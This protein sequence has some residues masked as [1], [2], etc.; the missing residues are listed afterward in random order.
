MMM[1][2]ILLMMMVG[3]AVGGDGA[4]GFGCS[5]PGGIGL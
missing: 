3:V 5:A 4:G 2:R 1:K